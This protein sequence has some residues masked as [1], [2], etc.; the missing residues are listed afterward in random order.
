M[1]FQDLVDAVQC[2]VPVHVRLLGGFVQAPVGDQVIK[3]HFP[4]VGMM[5]KVITAEAD[6]GRVDQIDD[7]F[8]TVSLDKLLGAQVDNPE[9]TVLFLMKDP[10]RIPLRFQGGCKTQR[11][12]GHQVFGS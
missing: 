7:I 1:I 5:L 4:E 11:V 2:G 8:V 10:G 9:N 6:D 12:T 3:H